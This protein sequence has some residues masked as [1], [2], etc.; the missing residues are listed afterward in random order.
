MLLPASVCQ[1]L[2]MYTIM[3]LF[4]FVTQP[5]LVWVPF[6]PVS[7]SQILEFQLWACV[8]CPSVCI[9]VVCACG[10]A[11]AVLFS[12][13]GQSRTLGVFLYHLCFCLLS[14]LEAVSVTE[15]EV[16]LFVKPGL[17]GNSW[18]LAAAMPSFL[19]EVLGFELRP[20][21]FQ[22]KHWFPAL[23]FCILWKVTGLSAEWIARH[24]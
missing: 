23:L 4:Y 14:R 10:Y 21:C 9:C 15:P 7:L 16:G 12:W 1:I 6:S 24:L 18:D 11:D 8:W 3:H 13:E 22:S 2:G 5:W 20:S 17:S 19:Q